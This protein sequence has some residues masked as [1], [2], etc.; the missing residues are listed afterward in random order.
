MARYYRRRRFGAYRKRFYRRR[1][2]AG[3]G[4]RKRPSSY[5][6]AYGFTKVFDQIIREDVPAE[7]KEDMQFLSAA[8]FMFITEK[9]DHDT[10]D[11]INTSWGT[12]VK[13]F[14]RLWLGPKINHMT[15]VDPKANLPESQ[16]TPGGEHVEPK[17]QEWGSVTTALKENVTLI[18]LK[19]QFKD[20]L[21]RC[22]KRN[23]P[24]A[25]ALASWCY[26]YLKNKRRKKK[27]F[28]WKYKSVPRYMIL[29]TLQ[30]KPIWENMKYGP[31]LLN[32]LQ[33]LS[34]VFNL[35]N[36]KTLLRLA[37]A[38]VG[39]ARQE[40]EKRHKVAANL[41]GIVTNKDVVSEL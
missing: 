9:L 7:R 17:L 15:N 30:M 27:F 11:T 5:N 22:T 29:L 3:G 20:A 4:N 18:A 32:L 31:S 37:Q 25:L 28:F 23:L 35:Q 16:M 24:F 14:G 6:I 34:F 2:G 33:E 1:F 13:I 26:S 36:E 10:A 19:R 38:G 41:T 39:A 8:S 21:Q 12:N 40:L